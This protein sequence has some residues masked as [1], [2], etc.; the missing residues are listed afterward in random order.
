MSAALAQ[1]LEC[2]LGKDEI[3]SSILEGGSTYFFNPINLF[4]LRSKFDFSFRKVFHCS[5]Q[6][7]K[8]NTLSLED[9]WKLSQLAFSFVDP[10]EASFFL[11]FYIFFKMKKPFL[12]LGLLG[13]VLGF[14]SVSAHIAEA[15]HSHTDHARYNRCSTN[16]HYPHYGYG[17]TWTRK[18]GRPYVRQYH[19]PKY[20]VPRRPVVRPMQLAC[21]NS[22]AYIT[23]DR[24][25]YAGGAQ[26]INAQ[27]GEIIRFYPDVNRTTSVNQGS[28]EWHYDSRNLD[29]E[30]TGNGSLTC[31]VT[32][33]YEADVWAGFR[34][35][36]GNTYYCANKVVASNKIYINQGTGMGYTTP[37]YNNSYNSWAGVTN[38]FQY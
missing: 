21:A 12:L 3:S 28:V 24:T 27:V 6:K 20:V 26:N 25:G 7:I 23:S 36:T 9:F 14:S 15:G 10:K 4:N 29:C 18:Y 35:N 34:S 11:S 37:Y 30:E 1:W 2:V 19:Q 31:T 33:L 38:F 32:G 17:R 5:A 13:L 22:S 16:H 8:I